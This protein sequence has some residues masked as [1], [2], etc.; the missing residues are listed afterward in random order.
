ML[1]FIIVVVCAPLC[2]F[3]RVCVCLYP[4][5]IHLPRSN[6]FVY[7]LLSVVKHNTTQHS[8]KNMQYSKSCVP[9]LLFFSGQQHFNFYKQQHNKQHTQQTL[10]PMRVP[11]FGSV[12]FP[13]SYDI[14]TWQNKPTNWAK[15]RFEPNT[16]S[17][18]SLVCFGLCECVCA[19]VSVS[20][21]VLGLIW[22][23]YNVCSAFRIRGFAGGTAVAVAVEHT[24]W[25][26]LRKTCS[27]DAVVAKPSEKRE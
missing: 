18:L 9:R 17:V 19:S 6:W 26:F 20:V 15:I 11:R 7:M 27:D 22:S 10:D 2:L 8:T 25:Q 16:L 13:Y 24:S 23:C 12:C 14:Q 5:A 1:L 4:S 3:L 21:F